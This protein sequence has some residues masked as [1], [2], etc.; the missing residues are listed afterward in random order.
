MLAFKKALILI[1]IITYVTMVSTTN[2]AFAGQKQTNPTLRHSSVNNNFMRTTNRIELK[3][4]YRDNR[5]TDNINSEAMPESPNESKADDR[6]VFKD[7]QMEIPNK[8]VT[9]KPNV[10]HNNDIILEIRTAIKAPEFCPEGQ[11]RINRT[12]RLDAD[13]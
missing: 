5:I 13:L 10:S 4:N 12:C 6:I 8:L 1:A 7:N 11:I 2:A 9:L 3:Y